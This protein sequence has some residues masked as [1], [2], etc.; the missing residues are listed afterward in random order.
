MNMDDVEYL[1]KE[2]IPG[3]EL[4]QAIDM[5]HSLVDPSYGLL[6]F[7]NFNIWPFVTEALFRQL[8]LRISIRVRVHGVNSYQTLI[9]VASRIW[10]R[11][12]SNEER[13]ISHFQCS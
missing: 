3:T 13:A 12:S 10:P 4:H 11:F 1:I 6:A 5:G 8:Q 9:L 7:G 2:A